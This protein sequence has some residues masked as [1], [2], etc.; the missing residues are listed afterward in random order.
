MGTAGIVL[1]GVSP[2]W[3]NRMAAFRSV[4][5]IST[6]VLL[7]SCAAKPPP[8]KRSSEYFPESVYGVKA[9]PR[10]VEY[11]QPVPQGGGR[12]LVGKQYKVKGKVYVPKED[13]RYTAVGYASWYGMAFHGRRTAN[14]EVYDMDALSAAHPTMPLPSYARVTNL[15]NGS[16]VVV[17]VND[18]GP[19]E[20]NR[21]I[22]LSSKTAEMLGVKRHGA[23]KVKV[24][25]VGP[26]RMEG[27][28]KQALMATYVPPRGGAPAL[29]PAPAPAR[30]QTGDTMLA[31]RAP[32]ASPSVVLAM[33]PIPR[34][35]P[36]L[37]GGI[38]IDPYNYEIQAAA[39][40]APAAAPRRAAAPAVAQP[41]VMQASAAGD[42]YAAGEEGYPAG[43]TNYGERSL[44][45]LTYSEGD[46]YQP[47]AA[48]EDVYLPQTSKSA[49]RSYAQSP[50][51]SPAQIALE[52]MARPASPALQ[53]SLQRAIERR[54]AERSADLVEIQVGV[55]RSA[56]NAAAI[57]A[58]L[59]SLGT[60]RVV[61]VEV[62]GKPMQAVRLLL[63][64]S[65]DG[66]AGLRA[67]A[68]AGASGAYIVR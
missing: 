37:G 3:P 62:G 14:G 8:S 16:S 68:A 47:S 56:D 52:T 26:A 7:A 31:M 45:T 11:G 59:A 49:A 54:A 66:E 58:R 20:R 27:H 36:E 21:V 13:S 43:G 22:D 12:Y 23:V 65:M 15:K 33:A 50:V 55:Y 53:A 2:K 41:Q 57:G 67:V 60:T 42:G 25:Y 28:D 30:M 39:L 10:V 24:E 38:A 6:A 18:R 40:E 32:I 61:E 64:P 48:N 19:Y 34:P 17:R 9:S 35:R 29:A 5:M 4:V 51:L 46:G 44:G 1:R 63:D